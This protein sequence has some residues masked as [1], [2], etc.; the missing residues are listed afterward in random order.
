MFDSR[1]N[2]FLD[3]MNDKLFRPHGLF[4]L[5][6]TYKPEQKASHEQ[7]DISK[8]ITKSITPSDSKVR[9]QLKGLKLSSGKTYGELEMPESAPLIF[10]ALDAVAASPDQ[11]GKKQ[12]KFKN[13]SKFVTDYLDR[14]AQ[15]SY[16]SPLL[17]Y[18]QSLRNSTDKPQA[19]ENPNSTL[20]VEQSGTTFASRYSDPNHPA[21]SGSLVSLITGGALVGGKERR[22]TRREA[23]GRRP[24]RERKGGLRKRLLQQ[25]SKKLDASMSLGGI[26]AYTVVVGCIVPDDCEHANG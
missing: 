24:R 15:A 19:K 26:R 5:I 7:V 12:S 6:M 25:V 11:D 1:T 10:P 2:S 22:R 20:A 21:S 18:T 4:C 16:V 23:R 17:S 3:Q 13:S 8:T 9:E 14:R